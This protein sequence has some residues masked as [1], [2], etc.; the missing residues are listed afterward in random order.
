MHTL[1]GHSSQVLSLSFSPDNDR[2]CSVGSADK[3]IRLWN[4]AD[5]KELEVSSVEYVERSVEEQTTETSSRATLL[6]PFSCGSS[7]TIMLV[8]ALLVLARA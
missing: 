8:A 3:S 6:V 1:K 5:G 4:P 2:L 7:A